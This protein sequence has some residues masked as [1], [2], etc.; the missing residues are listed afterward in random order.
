MAMQRCD[1]DLRA[2]AAE[3]GVS[4]GTVANCLKEA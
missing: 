3:V 4:V 2:I 1:A